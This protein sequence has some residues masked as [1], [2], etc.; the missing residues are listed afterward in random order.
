MT[1]YVALVDMQWFYLQRFNYIKY[2][3]V[4]VYNGCQLVHHQQWIIKTPPLESSFFTNLDRKTVQHV[5]GFNGIEWSMCGLKF[6]QV[7]VE[8][9]ATLNNVTDII[10]HGKLKAGVFNRT[11]HI[12]RLASQNRPIHFHPV[13]LYSKLPDRIVLTETMFKLRSFYFGGMGIAVMP[14]SPYECRYI[15]AACT[16]HSQCIYIHNNFVK[17]AESAPQG[18]D[19][20]APSKNTIVA[21]FK[22]SPST[23]TERSGC[24]NDS[25]CNE[26]SVSGDRDSGDDEVN[27]DIEYHVDDDLQNE[28]N[29]IILEL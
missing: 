19:E 22:A 17:G 18:D 13:T 8:L 12:Y 20:S 6:S 15:H 14:I 5:T 21:H 23:H 1:S 11:F 27:I 10:M 25:N 3:C 24:D 9:Y 4:E 28:L 26:D 16:K 29:N 2:L 7:L